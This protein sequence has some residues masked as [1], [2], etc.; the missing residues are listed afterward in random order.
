MT[1]EIKFYVKDKATGKRFAFTKVDGQG[2]D[3]C[4]FDY[5]DFGECIDMQEKS[6]QCE[7]PND[8]YFGT[9]HIFVE[10]PK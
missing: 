1:Q 3:G 9:T 2:C 4:Y 10:V 8:I 6:S 7:F 5:R